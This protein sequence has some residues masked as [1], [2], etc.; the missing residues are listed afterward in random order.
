MGTT[1]VPTTRRTLDLCCVLVPCTCQ[2]VLTRLANKQLKEGLA[3]GRQQ[4][5]AGLRQQPRPAREK[6]S[7]QDSTAVVG[8]TAGPI[9]GRCRRTERRHI[10]LPGRGQ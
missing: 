7:K 2:C 10:V 4:R 5:W 8:A 1:A 6:Q 9:K 3:R